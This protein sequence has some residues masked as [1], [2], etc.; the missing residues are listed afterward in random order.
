MT[1]QEIEIGTWYSSPHSESTYKVIDKGKD[2]L[3]VLCYSCVHYNCDAHFIKSDD[4]ILENWRV[5]DDD[6]EYYFDAF[7]YEDWQ[8]LKLDDL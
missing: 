1:F 5:D 3:C 8:T 7:L 4:E 6:N 2:W